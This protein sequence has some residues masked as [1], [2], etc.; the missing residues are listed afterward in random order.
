MWP[1]NLKALIDDFNES[2]Q[3]Y[4][5]LKK[6]LDLCR[7]IGYDFSFGLDCVPYNLEKITL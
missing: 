1:D 5:D 4:Q 3:D 2:N 6:L 7:R